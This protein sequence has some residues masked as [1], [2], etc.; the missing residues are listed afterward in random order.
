MC[1]HVGTLV[2][3]V[4]IH[5]PPVSDL[6]GVTL[7]I[8]LCTLHGVRCTGPVQLEQAGLNLQLGLVEIFMCLVYEVHVV[9]SEV[10]TLHMF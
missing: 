2:I 4:V 8:L 6:L 3:C 9:V 1:P 7:H 10:V 5:P